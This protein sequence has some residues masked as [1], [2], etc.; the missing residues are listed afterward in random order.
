M[1]VISAP[2][3]WIW[4]HCQYHWFYWTRTAVPPSYQVNYTVKKSPDLFPED[5]DLAVVQKVTGSSPAPAKN[6]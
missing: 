6:L 3:V 5:E 2:L 1:Q 4:R